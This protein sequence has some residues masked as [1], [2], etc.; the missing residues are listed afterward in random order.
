MEW[1]VE[2]ARGIGRMFLHPVFYFSIIWVLLAGFWRI[3][4]ERRDFLVRVHT[5]FLEL[6]HLFPAGI[7]VGVVLS[8]VSILLGLTIPLKLL[9]IV[10]LA[11]IILTV[12][13]N[14]RLLS[15]AFT[16]GIPLLLLSS[17]SLFS[18]EWNFLGP[19]DSNDLL[20]ASVMLGL[21]M[22][23]EGFL[24]LKNGLKDVSPKLRTSRRG[25]TVGALQTKRF[26]LLPS[27]LFLPSGVLTMPFDW[28]PVISSGSTGYSLVL[29]PFLLG[30]QQQIQTELPEAAVRRMGKNVLILGL[31]VLM[32][33]IVSALLLPVYAAII[34]SVFAL[35]GRIWI[36]YRHR[37][38]ENNYPYYFA[39]RNSGVMVLDVLPDSPADKMGLKTGEIIQTC[40][41]VKV[42]SKEEM[43]QALSKNRAY[44]KLE[45]FDHNNEIR[46]V[47]GA[48]Y[49]GDHHE[50]GIL[51]IENNQMGQTNRAI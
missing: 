42:N 9:F 41:K 34:T 45:V 16:I 23:A 13:G 47:Q 43:Y 50:L 21:L 19:M 26:W 24:M 39:P 38:R 25:L 27:F 11:T 36:A 6:R 51:F 40:N 15:A 29:L 32:A 37:I 22:V 10:A 28:W 46:I 44:C 48:L 7:L 30:F 17:F 3:K 33:S 31:L 18:F 14:A 2:I 35:L 5:I 8:I 49:E 12:I 4:R 20:G 1:T